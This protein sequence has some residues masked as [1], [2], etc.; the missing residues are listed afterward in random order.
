VA[1]AFGAEVFQVETGEINV[2]TKMHS[3]RQTGY[4]CPVG[5]EGANGGTIFESATCRD[6]LQVALSAAQAESMP[7]VACEWMKVVSG[8]NGVFFDGSKNVTLQELVDSAPINPNVMLKLS[9]P[10]MSHG[11]AKR[12][13]E[14]HFEKIA[15]PSLNSRFERF[16]F[17]NFE[18]T[19]MVESRTGDESGAWR[20]LLHA[21]N[22]RAFVFVRGSRTESGVWRMIIDADSPDD[23]DPLA[24]AAK[25]MFT[26][27]TEIGE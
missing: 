1:E 24:A 10:P 7:E 9:S 22:R 21:P 26:S 11:E 14:E 23:F 16:E 19:A 15:W 4:D 17:Q 5:V 12:R 3:L 13:M 20:A 6:G 18:E 27:A 2:V 8:L 25:T